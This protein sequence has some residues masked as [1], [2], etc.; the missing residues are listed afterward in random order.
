MSP[1]PLAL[2]LGDEEL[3]DSRHV[4]GLFEGAEQGRRAV[5]PMLLDGLRSGDRVVYLT[6]DPAT[7][8]DTLAREL[9][10]APLERSRHLDI[11][12]WTAAYLQGARFSG[13]RMLGLLRSIFHDGPT[14][15]FAASRVVGEMEWAQDGV[16]GVEELVTYE[17]G[18]DALIGHP[19]N[20]VV[21]LYDL[22]Q[23]TASRIAAAAAAHDAVFIG[24]Q[25]EQSARLARSTKPRDRILAA[26]G[27]LFSE[28][29]VRGTG[30][31]TIIEASRVAKAT[32]YRHFPSKDELIV[33]WLEDGGTRWFD[34]VVGR[35][36]AKA[37]APGDV[38][39]QL[40]L[41]LAEWVEAGGYRGSAHL[42]TMIELGDPDHPAASPVTSIF[43]HVRRSL[44]EIA[45]AAGCRDPARVATELQMIL[46]G[47]V[48]LSVV[49]RSTSFMDTACEAATAVIREAGGEVRQPVS[50]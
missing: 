8:R 4:C 34:E 44:A 31:D 29:G 5:L 16:P 12:P 38:I 46:L 41:A 49:Y 15:G 43:D 9:D 20:V 25:L 19:P 11:R 3:G 30:V 24:G 50:G 27:R 48:H 7:I 40:C 14:D 32:F 47:A 36:K 37:A 26:A 6:K 10:V 28:R 35:A 17:R 42:N 13:S 18:I 1:Q 45:A 21:C 23:H 33:A 22:G 2:R 39:P